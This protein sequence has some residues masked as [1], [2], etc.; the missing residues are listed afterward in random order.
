MTRPNCVSE[1]K[2]FAI[3]GGRL[4]LPVGPGDHV[5]ARAVAGRA[6]ADVPVVEGVHVGQLH[7]VV[8]ALLDLGHAQHDRLGPQVRLDHRVRRVG[9]GRDDG[10]VLRCRGLGIVPDRVERSL[11]LGVRLVH[12]ELVQRLVGRDHR[13][14]VDVGFLGD[15][16]GLERAGLVLRFGLRDGVRLPAAAGRDGG[17]ERE[18]VQG[19]LGDDH[20]ESSFCTEADP[21]NRI[22]SAH[23]SWGHSHVRFLRTF[24]GV[25]T[26]RR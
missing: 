19:L 6:A 22:R 2:T 21:I 11:V 18:G 8:A 7:R 10:G 25:A 1:R 15:R 13:E 26:R 9:I 4:A 24:E 14:A 23:A 3:A 5:A 16:L 17:R 20:R 12:V